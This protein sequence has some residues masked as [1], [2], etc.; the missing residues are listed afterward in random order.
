L[1]ALTDAMQLRLTDVLREE[2]SGSYDP[3]VV[4][5]CSRGPRDEYGLEVQFGSGPES[6]ESLT[7]AVFSMVESL[8]TKGPTAEE[9]SKVKEQLARQR[10]VSVRENAYWLVNLAARDQSGER[11]DGLLAPYDA[12]IASLSREQIRAA[13]RQYLNVNNYARFV[14]LP[15]TSDPRR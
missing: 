6:V 8:Q 12:M 14:L 10:E 13:A 7:R 3:R 2:M 4:S 11:F 5:A 15:E 9:V 1:R